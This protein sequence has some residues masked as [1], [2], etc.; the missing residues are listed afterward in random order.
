ML[1]IIITAQMI[2]P[3]ETESRGVNGLIVGVATELKM[4]ARVEDLRFMHYLNIY[5]KHCHLQLSKCQITS[6]NYYW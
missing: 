5:Q 1:C 2:K 4:Q 3:L 6:V